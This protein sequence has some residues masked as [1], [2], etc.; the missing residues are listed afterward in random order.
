MANAADHGQL[1]D[2]TYRYQR[3][4][5]DLTRKYYLLGRDEMIRAMDVQ[6]GQS[7]LEV[8]CGTGRNLQLIGKT[9]P[10]ARLYGFDISEEMLISARAKLGAKAT[11]A[12]GDACDFAPDGLFDVA[13]FDHIVLSYS[14]SMIPDWQGA[15]RE[16]LRHLAPGGTLHI[17]DF[18]NQS[19]LPAWFKRSLRAWL[20][21]FHVTPRDDLFAEL[22]TMVADPA[23]LT[24]AEWYRGY[25]FSAVYR[26]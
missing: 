15:V 12:Q 22:K 25:A 10:K 4:I 6:D 7:V 8:A 21:R 16:A 11:L 19:R 14:L 17:V 9:Y 26:A 24:C 5:Y 1:M 3:Y 20:L 2:Q 23:G 18:G 13:G